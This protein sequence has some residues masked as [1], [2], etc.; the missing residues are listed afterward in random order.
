MKTVYLREQ[1]GYK[2]QDFCNLFDL[3]LEEVIRVVKKLKEYGVLKAV[4]AK[5]YQK[6]LSE[7]LEEDIEISD[8]A[9]TDNDR[10]YVFVYVGIITIGDRVIICYPK[11]LQSGYKIPNEEMRQ[12]IKVIEKYNSKEQVIK[13]FNDSFEAK[14]F[15]L[16]AVLVFLINDY[17]EHGP[18]NKSEYVTE[19]NGTGEI[20]W[21]KTINE[22]F[23]I[24][25]NRRPYYPELYTKKRV[26]DDHDYFKRLHEC[27]VS[28][29]SKEL[30]DASL[31]DLFELKAVD[32]SEEKLDDF[33]DKEYILYRIENELAVQFNTHKQL[34]LK[35]LYSYI[36]HNDHLFDIDCFSMVGTNCF[37]L[38]WEDVCKVIL[39]DMLQFKLKDLGIKLKG[40][41]YVS[42]DNKKLID[43]IEKPYWSVTDSEAETLKPDLITIVDD[44]FVIFDAKYYKPILEQGRPPEGQP[45]IDSII[46]QFFYQMVYQDFIKSHGLKTVNC[47]IIPTAN[48]QEDVNKGVVQMRQLQNTKIDLEG[49]T[50][51]LEDIQVRLLFAPKAFDYYL[52]GRLYPIEEL[53]LDSH[54]SKVTSA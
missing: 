53:K 16:L 45:G 28:L 4:R 39:N 9:D 13:M 1:E 40:N 49:N 35:V 14:S 11:Y 25:S 29:A 27:I 51:G 8:A 37:N 21:D 23:A 34:V 54:V 46:K 36:A 6:N 15:N 47:F 43:I 33:G 41:E 52:N 31:L 38:V 7:L 42:H 26:T 10:Y 5:D 22:S 12:I 18:Y 20:L 2:L 3:S 17:H 19:S 32:A 24:I 48:P 44:L 50:I 30:N